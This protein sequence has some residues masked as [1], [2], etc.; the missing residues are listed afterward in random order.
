MD[1][2]VL[3]SRVEGI[4][5]AIMEAAA[6]GAV[7]IASAVGGV[8]DLVLPGFSGYLAAP[9]DP[10]ALAAALLALAGTPDWLASEMAAN[11]R[12]IVRRRMTWT[13]TVRDY[14]ALI[15]QG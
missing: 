10:G 6:C 15:A 8:P 7:P 5:L 14:A 4:P 12:A 9:D 11:A 2:Y 13:Q 1:A 3:P